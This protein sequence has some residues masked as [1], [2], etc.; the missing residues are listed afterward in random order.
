MGMRVAVRGARW[1]APW[2]FGSE[3]HTCLAC[4]VCRNGYGDESGIG[5]L[6]CGDPAP[7]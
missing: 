7:L 4:D 1:D 5:T 3:V 6:E 2:R